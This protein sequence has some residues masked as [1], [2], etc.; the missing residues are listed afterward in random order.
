[1]LYG[2]YVLTN[3]N[4][5]AIARITDMRYTDEWTYFELEYNYT[6]EID[7]DLLENFGYNFTVV[8]SSSK[9]GAT[10]EGAI[11]STLC[12]DKVRVICKTRE[13]IEEEDAE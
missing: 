4:I 13:E 12:V 3:E 7:Y 9:D 1:M 11:G 5:V 10:F 2:D 6:E 8:F